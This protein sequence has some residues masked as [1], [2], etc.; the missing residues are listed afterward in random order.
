MSL[1]ETGAA[2]ISAAVQ[3]GF[4]LA[5]GSSVN[6]DGHGHIHAGADVDA[7]IRGG[8]CDAASDCE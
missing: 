7:D 3:P 1:L 4:G 2:S 6:I 8:K 5:S